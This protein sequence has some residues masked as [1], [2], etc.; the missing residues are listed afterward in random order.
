MRTLPTNNG[1]PAHDNNHPDAHYENF[2]VASWLCPATIR[3]AVVALYRFARTADDLADEGELSA[4]Q[5]LVS[6][7]NYRG[8]LQATYTEDAPEDGPWTH[9][10]QPLRA[11]IVRHALPLLPLHDLITAFERDVHNTRNGH[12]YA[13]WDELADYAR[14][15]A[16]PVGRLMLHLYGMDDAASL[17]Q[18]DAICT[19]LQYYNF[20]QDLSV[21]IPRQR[22]YLPSSLCEPLGIDPR[23]PQI[24][25]RQ[26]QT[27]LLQA[28]LAHTDTLMQHGSSL[29]NRLAQQPRK[30]SRLSALELQLVMQGGW[31]MGQKTRQMGARVMTH[32]P[33]LRPLDWLLVATRGLFKPLPG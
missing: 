19:A 26:A 27:A 30:G 29:P 21:D 9:V 8:S 23:Q 14:H 16:N 32:R 18:S 10:M 13:D 1:S 6:L 24:A 11:A 22:Y 2:P 33:V 7:E 28:L 4:D 20:W 5:R 3:P 15:S 25:G 17:Q 31:R 12:V